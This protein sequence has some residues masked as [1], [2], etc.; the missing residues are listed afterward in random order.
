MMA[1]NDE[2]LPANDD[3]LSGWA[4]RCRAAKTPG[5]P[6]SARQF[7]DAR[8]WG[9]IPDPDD[10]GRWPAQAARW[11][12][13]F[14]ALGETVRPLPR[15][16]LRLRC[17]LSDVPVPHA[18]LREAMLAI[19]PTIKAPGRKMKQI[20]VACVKWGRFS[21]G[22]IEDEMLAALVS[23]KREAVWLPP[24]SGRWDELLRT[25]PTIFFAWCMGQAFYEHAPILAF[26]RHW[27]SELAG[28]IEKIPIE[29][30]MTILTI[31]NIAVCLER[32]WCM[33]KETSTQ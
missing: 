29:E 15:R 14:A 22:L 13:R 17:E 26:A 33:P 7:N 23:P 27:E 11:L 9:A 1:M 19:R 6:I 3:T 21:A 2:L 30:R 18:T 31:R 12:E 28:Q 5:N 10:Q 8:R 20:D 4:L 32:G 16:I 25:G 24:E